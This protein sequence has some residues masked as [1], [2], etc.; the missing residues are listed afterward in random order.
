MLISFFGIDG[1]DYSQ[2]TSDKNNMTVIPNHPSF[3]CPWL[4]IKLK[5]HHFYTIWNDQGRI[6]GDTEHLHEHD[7]QDVFKNGRSAGNSASVWKGTT[8]RVMVASSPKV[9]FGPDCGTSPEDY[10]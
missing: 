9:S 1:I 7:L 10:G 4:K 8:S 6:I 2:R 5:D 3:L